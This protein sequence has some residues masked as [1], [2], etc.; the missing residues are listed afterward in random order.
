MGPLRLL[1]TFTPEG[2][3]KSRFLR[4]MSTSSLI[5]LSQMSRTEDSRSPS[6]SSALVLL[7]H[8]AGTSTIPT[9]IS[10]WRPILSVSNQVVLYNPT[11]HALTV[12]THSGHTASLCPY[13]HRPMDDLA[14]S[15]TY[16]TPRHTRAPNY[17]QLLEVVNETN[18]VPG[19]PNGSS[20]RSWLQDEGFDEDSVRPLNGESN[21][22]SVFGS[23]VMAEGYF[24]AFFK[25]ERRLGM[26]AN[27]TVF[28]CQVRHTTP[29]FIHAIESFLAACPRWESLGSFRREEDCCRT[30]AYLSV[31][32]TKRG[33]YIC[34]PHHLSS[35]SYSRSG[36]SNLYAI[37]ILLHITTR[38]SNLANSLRSALEFQRCCASPHP[39][40]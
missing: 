7:P 12:R 38:G 26:G 19:T 17:F 32:D 29:V 36:F 8:Q 9:V 24:E 34:Q 11:S 15:P 2:L 27:G 35:L 13:C 20:R 14:D 18:S 40:S 21:S 6:P 23:G 5:N 22:T 1:S 39:M 4:S 31:A 3:K 37:P 16:G 33:I 30:I 28:L 10:A 25:E